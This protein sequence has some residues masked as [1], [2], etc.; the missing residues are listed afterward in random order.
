MMVP[1]NDTMSNDLLYRNG[2][3]KKCVFVVERHSVRKT[4]IRSN[5]VRKLKLKQYKRGGKSPSDIASI[6]LALTRNLQVKVIIERELILCENSSIIFFFNFIVTIQ[7]I[8]VYEAIK[9]EH[10]HVNHAPLIT[11]LHMHLSQDEVVLYVG[12]NRGN[13]SRVLFQE[14]R[15]VTGHVTVLIINEVAPGLLGIL[16]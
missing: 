12:G 13:V 4:I 9:Y 10:L 2:S 7:Q 1:V 16:V 15:I 3:R 8:N 6:C 14:S 11:N 5:A